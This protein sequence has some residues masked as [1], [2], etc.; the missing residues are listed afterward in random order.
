[1]F[2]PAILMPLSA[3]C[4]CVLQDL[5]GAAAYSP[6]L[7]ANDLAAREAALAKKEAAMAAREAELNK[8]EGELKRA[9]GPK[10]NWPICF[11]FVHHDI[12]NDIPSHL[13]SMVRQVYMAFLV[14]PAEGSGT[15]ESMF[16]FVGH[17]RAVNLSAAVTARVSTEPAPETPLLALPA[18]LLHHDS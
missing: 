15:R 6:A 11:A 7:A 5:G 3:T 2:H 14:S 4:H 18:A 8:R 9:K 16:C 1:M 12:A 17:C 10:K 13:R